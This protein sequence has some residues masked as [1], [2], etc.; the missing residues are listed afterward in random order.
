M[1]DL[2]I[3]PLEDVPVNGEEVRNRNFLGRIGVNAI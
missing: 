2:I 1:L 3:D